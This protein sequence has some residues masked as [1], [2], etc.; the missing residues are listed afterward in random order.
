MNAMKKSELVDYVARHA[1]LPRAQAQAA[2]DG[3]LGGVAGALARGG[4][5]RL[6]GFGTFAVTRRV[7]STGRNP[8]TGAA[9]AIPSMNR[10]V[11]RSSRKLKASIAGDPVTRPMVS[12]NPVTGP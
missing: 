10:P 6:S 12:G 8:R 1:G 2:V 11:F 3:V 9:L 7:A 4:E 5:V